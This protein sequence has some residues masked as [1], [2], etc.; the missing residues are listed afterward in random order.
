MRK[1]GIQKYISLMRYVNPPQLK[2]KIDPL[3][4]TF[5]SG[6]LS[7]KEWDGAKGRDCKL[8]YRNFHHQR[9]H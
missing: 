1:G 4:A 7:S 2:Q 8:K 5:G 6:E 3:I 9:V